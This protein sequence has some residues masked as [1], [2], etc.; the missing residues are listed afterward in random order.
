MITANKIAYSV[1]ENVNQF[2]LTSEERIPLRLLYKKIND[3]RSTI[4]KNRLPFVADELYQHLECLEVENYRMN[5]GPCP[6]DT[7]IKL[8]RLPT[9]L[10]VLGNKQIRYIGFDDFNA[11]NKVNIVSFSSFITYNSRS[12]TAYTPVGTRLPEGIVLKIPGKCN[13]KYLTAIV[14]LSDPM[15]A[16]GCRQIGP[17]DAYPI[18]Q[19]Y[20][21]ELEIMLKKDINSGYSPATPG[22]YSENKSDNPQD[23]RKNPITST[24]P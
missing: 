23:A 3:G 16:I 1:L 22:D 18:P 14:A 6:S 9:T 15:E 4:A 12:Y 7:V 20:L 8:L 21:I 24:I 19:D 5:C 17:D 13:F 2:K 11:D 10:S